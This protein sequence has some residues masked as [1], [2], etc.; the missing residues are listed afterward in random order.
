[1]IFGLT[2]R[3]EEGTGWRQ[4]LK[5]SFIIYALHLLLGDNIKE[6]VIGGASST[7]EVVKSVYKILIKNPEGEKVF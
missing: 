2:K 6:G 3:D 1:V 5:R 7:R 4:L